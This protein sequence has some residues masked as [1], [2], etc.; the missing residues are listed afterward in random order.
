MYPRSEPFLGFVMHPFFLECT[1]I[2]TPLLLMFDRVVSRH[3]LALSLSLCVRLLVRFSLS[4]FVY[5][6]S[7]F[8]VFRHTFMNKEP[9]S[10]SSIS[11]IISPSFSHSHHTSCP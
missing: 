6:V 5:T 4:L 1:H 8:S 10:P 9:R 7:F 2:C 3:H 11:Y